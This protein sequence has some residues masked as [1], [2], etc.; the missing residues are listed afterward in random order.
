MISLESMRRSVKD[1]QKLAK[2]KNFRSYNLKL[3]TWRRSIPKVLNSLPKGGGRIEAGMARV[4]PRPITGL[5]ILP[6]RKS[7]VSARKT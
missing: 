2:N 7:G 3:Q 4:Q 6:L 5:V 1:G